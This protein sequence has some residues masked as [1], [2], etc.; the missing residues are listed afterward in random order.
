MQKIHWPSAL[1]SILTLVGLFLLILPL[2][3][4]AQYYTRQFAL[5]ALILL[6]LVLGGIS[7]V[8]LYELYKSGYYD[9]K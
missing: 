5:G 3:Y 9:K 2:F 4:L 7:L 1:K 8:S 6:T